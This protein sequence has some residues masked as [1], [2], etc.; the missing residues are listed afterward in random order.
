MEWQYG[1]VSS[2]IM[3][4]AMEAHRSP[5]CRFPEHV[6]HGALEIEFPA[7]GS[8]AIPEYPMPFFYKGNQIATRRVD[9]LV[10]NIIPTEIRAVGLPE[11]S[12]L[13]Q[14]LNYREAYNPEGGM[15]HNFGN[16]SLQYKRIINKR[17]K[18]CITV[19]LKTTSQTINIESY[20]SC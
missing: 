18:G 14:A 12:H 11:D 20:K 1:N 2:G 10:D 9:F 16:V 5:G 17:Y 3:A 6:H 13:A 4:A 15:K 19:N 7:Q 8:D